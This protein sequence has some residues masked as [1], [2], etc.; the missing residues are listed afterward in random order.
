MMKLLAIVMGCVALD[1]LEA[2][3]QVADLAQTHAE[4]VQVK[5]LAEGPKKKAELQP[6]WS[7]CHN[8]YSGAWE[9][10]KQRSC[11]VQSHGGMSGRP[12]DHPECRKCA[13]VDDVGFG[14]GNSKGFAHNSHISYSTRGRRHS[15]QSNADSYETLGT[16]LNPTLK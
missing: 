8:T 9:C 13:A 14:M 16:E 4:L 10:V 5:E 7:C 2:A 12:K 3:E 15:M 6:G 11:P 1:D